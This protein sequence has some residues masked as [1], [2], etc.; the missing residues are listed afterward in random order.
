[1]LVLA[2]VWRLRAH[3]GLG[4]LLNALLVGTFVILLTALEP[5]NALSEEGLGV[6]I[7]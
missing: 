2:L 7:C 6:R 3:V 4:T 1:M 5:V